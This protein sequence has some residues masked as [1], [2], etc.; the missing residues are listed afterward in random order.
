VVEEGAGNWVEEQKRKR[1]GLEVVE[2]AG[3]PPVEADIEA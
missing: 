1:P 3:R 2:G